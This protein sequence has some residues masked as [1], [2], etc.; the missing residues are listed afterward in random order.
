MRQ[1]GERQDCGI[2]TRYGAAQVRENQNNVTK[3]SEHSFGFAIDI[4]ARKSQ[5]R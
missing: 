5:P 1:N 3:L 4:N 2:R